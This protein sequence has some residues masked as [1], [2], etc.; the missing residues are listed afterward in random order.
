ML[1]PCPSRPAEESVEPLPL[2]H[3]GHP[4]RGM[5]ALVAQLGLPTPASDE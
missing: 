4:Y 1:S 3:L 5:P 2:G